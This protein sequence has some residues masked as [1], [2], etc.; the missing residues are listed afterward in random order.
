MRIG[1]ERTL[2]PLVRQ[3]RPN[4]DFRPVLD[5]GAE[6]A[7]FLSQQAEGFLHLHSARFSLSLLQDQR[8]VAPTASFA[9][10]T[11]AIPRIGALAVSAALRTNPFPANIDPAAVEERLPAAMEHR[12]QLARSLVS[13][14]PPPDWRTW[15]L[16]A[17]QAEEEW[18]WG[19]LGSVDERFYGLVRDYLARAH[20]PQEA[21]QTFAFV[22]DLAAWDFARAAAEADPLIER[23]ARGEDWIP[24]ETLLDGAFA[25]RYLTGD[26]AGARRTLERLGPRIHDEGERTV[27]RLMAADLSASRASPR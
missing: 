8:R 7:R 25:A 12:N 27:M 23:A 2:G 5:L 6:R 21:L 19:S 17:L 3:A 22:H 4:S 10:P 24:P 1:S 9:V 14:A 20:A 13:S 18:H 26:L 11:P 16:G 15:T